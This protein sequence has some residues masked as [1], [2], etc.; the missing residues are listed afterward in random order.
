MA[1]KLL[2]S[3]G[4]FWLATRPNFAGSWSQAGGIARYGQ[5]GLFWFAVPRE[6]WPEDPEYVSAIEAQWVEPYGDRRQ[7]LVFIGQGL[8]KGELINLRSA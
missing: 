2:R 8:D 7:E 1:G 3:K 4:F 6:E 5:A